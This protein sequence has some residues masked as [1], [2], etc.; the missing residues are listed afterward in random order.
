LERSFWRSRNVF[1]VEVEP[2]IS[3]V[4]ERLNRLFIEVEPP[5]SF[6]CGSTSIKRPLQRNLYK[7]LSK[8]RRFDLS[9]VWR[10]KKLKELS[11][12]KLAKF[13]KAT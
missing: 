2:L 8:K 13:L 4:L 12:K 6:D 10:K 1:F 7:D 5:T 3:E 11:K 9:K